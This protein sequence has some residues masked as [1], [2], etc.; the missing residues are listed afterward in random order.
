ME[1][2]T[3]ETSTANQNHDSDKSSTNGKN[4]L[5]GEKKSVPFTA[6]DLREME[7]EHYQFHVNV[8]KTKPDVAKKI[9]ASAIKPLKEEM[10]FLVRNN[11]N[12]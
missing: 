2:K 9:V 7:Q 6:K 3:S 10:Q 5:N 11:S 12:K 4:S 8:L 1:D